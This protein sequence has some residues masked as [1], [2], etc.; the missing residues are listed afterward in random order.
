MTTSIARDGLVKFLS[1]TG[2]PPRILAVADAERLPADE[3]IEFA[4]VLAI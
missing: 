2:H 1:A 3:P 4:P